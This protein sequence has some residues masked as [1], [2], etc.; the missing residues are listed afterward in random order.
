MISDTQVSFISHT[1]K[2]RGDASNH[3]YTADA[4]ANAHRLFRGLK[5]KLVDCLQAANSVPSN[6]MTNWIL[7]EKFLE[8]YPH[9]S[10]VKALWETKWKF[11]CSLGVYPFH[12][13]KLEDFAP[14]FDN[15]IRDN[16]NDAYSDTYTQ[17]FLPTAEKLTD[18]ALSAQASDRAKAA[19][20]FNRAACVYRISRFPSLDAGPGLKKQ[21]FEM[22][23]QVY[24]RGASLWD[25]PMKEIKIPHSAAEGLDGKE[26]PL[27]V[28]LPPGASEERK[29]PMV[30][31]ITGLDGHRPDNTGVSHVHPPADPGD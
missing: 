11:P 21:I 3:P 30:L 5:H 8:R 22:Q 31:L 27:F 9:L 24:L 28:R 26:I 7:G 1:Y 17:Y 4:P 23:K 13:G 19:E 15:L 6:N 14:I 10:G 18:A 12:D 25:A 29:C 2:D 16:V 20:L